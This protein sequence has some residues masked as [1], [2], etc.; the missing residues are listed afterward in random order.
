[1]GA[2]IAYSII[3]ASLANYPMIPSIQY[4]RYYWFGSLNLILI[5]VLSKNFNS[6]PPR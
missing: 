4:C 5:G 3:P 2:F 6:S 1:L